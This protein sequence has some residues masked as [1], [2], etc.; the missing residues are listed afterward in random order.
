MQ[1]CPDKM[2]RAMGACCPR[3]GVVVL[4]SL[5]PVVTETGRAALEAL[6]EAGV[7]S[8]AGCR[9]SPQ[10]VEETSSSCPLGGRL[11]GRD[12]GGFQSPMKQAIWGQLGF[13]K[14]HC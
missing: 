9:A 7:R 12:G 2:L 8:H 10:A 6:L 13:M 14:W 5:G 4:R 1:K 3:S 11:R